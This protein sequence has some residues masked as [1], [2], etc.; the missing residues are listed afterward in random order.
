MESSLAFRRWDIVILSTEVEPCR[1]ESNSK[2]RVWEPLGFD[3]V[4]TWRKTR[5]SDLM[6]DGFIEAKECMLL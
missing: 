6:S 5:M 2:G 1:I 4:L 3:E